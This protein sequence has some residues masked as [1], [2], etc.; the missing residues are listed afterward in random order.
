MKIF[1]KIGL[2][3]A[4]IIL[5]FIIG[6]VFLELGLRAVNPQPIKPMLFAFHPQLGF[7]HVP[8]QKGRRSYPGAFSYTYRNNS[9]GLRANR[10]YTQEKTKD[11]RIIILGDSF[12]YGIGVDDDQTLPFQIEIG[13]SNLGHSVE[14]INAGSAG[15]GTDYALKFFQTLGYKLKP[16]LTILCF[17]PNDF[18]ENEFSVYYNFSQDGKLIVNSL[19]NSLMQKKD[20]LRRLPLYNWLLTWSHLANLIKLKAAN[21]IAAIEVSRGIH[22]GWVYHYPTKG[23]FYSNE[24]NIKLTAILIE[25]LREAVQAADS[26]LIFLYLPYRDEVEYYRQTRKLSGDEIAFNNLL[27]S[28][29]EN[30][31]SLTSILAD[32]TK[33]IDQLYFPKDPHPTPAANSIMA[34]FM[35]SQIE[36]HIKRNLR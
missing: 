10:E 4:A 28:Q 14:V 24:H 36:E 8:N 3:M 5:G 21:I 2:R 7:I 23:E 18:I 22:T 31:L 19:P 1:K 34:D 25:Q 30:L 12:I 27:I 6:F 16:D 11:Y 20:F 26:E 29:Q 33:T 15:K 17:T 35:G 9:Y 13:L 32:S